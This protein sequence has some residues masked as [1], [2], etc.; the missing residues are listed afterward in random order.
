MLRWYTI[1]VSVSCL[2]P[3]AGFSAVIFFQD[4]LAGFEAAAGVAVPIQIDFDSLA[5]GSDLDG[6]TLA[7]ATLSSPDGNTLEVVAGLST[8]TPGGFTGVVDPDTN[9]LFPTTGDN[10]LSPGGEALVPGSALEE[11]DSLEVVFDVPQRAVGLDVLFQS[12]DSGVTTPTV[13]VFDAAGSSVGLMNIVGTGP[14]GS[15]GG[16]IF[17]GFVSDDPL[18]NISRLLVREIDGDAQ[19]PDSNIGYDTLRYVVPLPA[20][21]FLLISALLALVAT[22]RRPMG[23]PG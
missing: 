6:A 19:F 5:V 14:G 18:T 16:A 13:E 15:P 17:V 21:A 8:F 4:D 12:I 22:V 2:V 7:G 9:R 20:A 1:I 10:V 3:I 23:G 11:K